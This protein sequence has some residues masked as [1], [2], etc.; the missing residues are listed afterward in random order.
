MSDG[1][2]TTTDAGTIQS[3]AS[4]ASTETTGTAS[5]ATTVTR[6]DWLPEDHWDGAANVIKPE[7]GAHYAEIKAVA[8]AEAA[9]RATIFTKPEDVKFEVKLP[10]G[11]KAPDGM[12]LR[13]NE[14]DPRV[15]VL[16]EMA[17]KRGWD[18]DT[19]N[20]L[21]ALDAQMQIQN[22]AAQMTRLAA[23]DQK[24]GVNAKAR[25]DA[26]GGWLKGMKDRNELS[27]E[28]YEAVRIYA[29]DATTVTALEK[30]M[31]KASGNVPGRQ[32]DPP[33]AA[34]EKSAAERM[35]PHLPS[36]LPPASAR[37]A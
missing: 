37:S 28:E 21:V 23:E 7:F 35:Y 20:E 19:V 22:H 15:P 18:Q 32:Q 1:A 8:D 3:G 36:G 10:D 24:L 16:R 30:I 11:V 13:I 29:T 26:V 31:A 6:P 14:N 34:Q 27:G 25:K 17:V 33:P 4:A 2:T 9:R 12:D 5:T